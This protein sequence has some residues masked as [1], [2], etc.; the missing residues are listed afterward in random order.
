[1][2]HMTEFGMVLTSVVLVTLALGG[3][4]YWAYQKYVVGLLQREKKIAEAA[5]ELQ[6]WAIADAN[7]RRMI[8][9]V[10]NLN[11]ALNETVKVFGETKI[12]SLDLTRG[13]SLKVT[14]EEIKKKAQF[15]S[16]DFN[17]KLAQELKSNNGGGDSHQSVKPNFEKSPK[18]FNN[19]NGNKNVSGNN[20]KIFADAAK[21]VGLKFHEF[22]KYGQEVSE[23]FSVD[24][25][26]QMSLDE[27]E[28][29]KE[30]ISMKAGEDR[31]L[32]QVNR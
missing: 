20:N 22:L 30:A 15:L 29:T 6:T 13:R 14:L 21:D 1:M 7:A 11:D 19:D 23:Y 32:R 31:K 27:R 25:F 8:T 16:N 9:M 28:V 3:A 2:T 26:A 10:T 4:G 12:S 18:P 17:D 24:T 5:A